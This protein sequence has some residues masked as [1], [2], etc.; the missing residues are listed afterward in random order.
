MDFVRG[1]DLL[2]HLLNLG[3]FTEEETKFIIA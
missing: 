2:M 1:G 3:S